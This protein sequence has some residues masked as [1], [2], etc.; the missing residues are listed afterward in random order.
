MRFEKVARSLVAALVA[1]AAVVVL[2]TAAAR[3]ASVVN[4]PLTATASAPRAKGRAVLA[5]R[6]TSKGAFTVRGRGLAANHPFDVVVGGIKVG[7]FTTNAHGV[8]K[9]TFRTASG[10]RAAKVRGHKLLLGFD[11]RGNVVIVRDR[12]TSDDDLRCR[13]PGGDDSASGAF[14][15][16]GPQRDGSGD[17]PCATK[18][19]AECTADGGTPTSVTSCVPNPCP[20]TPPPGA[21]CCIPG[22]ADGAFMHDDDDDDFEIECEDVASVEACVAK[23]GAVVTATSCHPNPC[24]PA[25]PSTVCC[26][27]ESAASAFIRDDDDESP[28]SQCVSH[29]SPDACRAAGGT[30]VSAGS[31]HPNP[32]GPNTPPAVACCLGGDDDEAECKMLAPDACMNAGGMV[33]GTSCSSDPCPGG[34]DDH[35]GDEDHGN[36]GQHG[37]QGNQG[38]HGNHQGN[39]D[40]QGQDD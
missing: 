8:G 29:T 14:A 22:S 9:A 2:S 11:P 3:D 27:P 12:K 36:H 19:P 13:F 37:D 16:C 7:G 39:Q 17:V 35:P 24:V 1:S 25:P 15:C 23:G 38:D 21:V 6:A 4:A 20:P 33:S 10:K 18:T 34:D 31:C 28:P 26:L 30:T 32:C 40:D 5:L